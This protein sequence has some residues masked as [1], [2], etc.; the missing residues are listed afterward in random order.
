MEVDDVGGA[1][2]AVMTI[3][4]DAGWLAAGAVDWAAAAVA[5]DCVDVCGAGNKRLV[6]WAGDAG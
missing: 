4:G 5:A 3:A 2:G 6:T 1:A